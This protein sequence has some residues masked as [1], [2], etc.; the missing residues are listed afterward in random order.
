MRILNKTLPAIL[1]LG[2][3][4]AGQPTPISFLTYIRQLKSTVLHKAIWLH[5]EIFSSK[6]IIGNNN[7]IKTQTLAFEGDENESNCLCYRFLCWR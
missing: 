7:L 4:A 3:V 6:V 5:R 1:A 2:L